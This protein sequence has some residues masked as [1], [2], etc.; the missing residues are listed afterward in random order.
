M[1]I[2][3]DNETRLVVQGITGRQGRFHTER[4]LQSK[5]QIVAGVT[6]GKGGEEYLPVAVRSP[7]SP[8]E[9]ED[10][11]SLTELLVKVEGPPFIVGQLEGRYP[12]SYAYAGARF[13]H[14]ASHSVSFSCLLI[15][16]RA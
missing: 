5:T 9:D 1:A 7:I 4:M 6:P 12:Y 15:P 11:R 13:G 10:Q 14:A 8:V 3:V 2:L 16:A